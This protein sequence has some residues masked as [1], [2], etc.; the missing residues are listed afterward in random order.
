MRIPIRISLAAAA[1]LFALVTTVAA[2]ADPTPAARYICPPCSQ[3]CDTMSFDHPGTCPACGMTLVLAADAGTPPDTRRKVAILVFPGVEIIDSMGPYEV[4]GAA[5][6]NVYSVGA[7]RDP[8][9]SAMG[10][11][12]TP[13]YTFDDAPVPDVLVV[14]GGGVGNALHSDRT[15]DWI[16]AITGKDGQTMSVCNGAFILA[17]AGL[18]DGLSATTTA[19]NI[20]KLAEQYPKIHVVSDQRY[21]DNGHIVTTAGLSAGIDGALHVVARLDGDGFAQEVALA[22]EYPWTPKGG[23]ARAAMADQLIPQVDFDALG[24][25]KLVSTHGTV[26]HWEIVVRGTS[27][28]SAAELMDKVSHTLSEKGKWRPAT[29]TRSASANDPIENRWRFAGQKGEPWRGTV[30][31]T[32]VRGE[33]RAYVATLRVAQGG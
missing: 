33:E 4:F 32:P 19:H 21:V 25:W 20:P 29:G 30:T 18:L 9:T 17:S 3:P 27:T 13:K 2:Y 1:V 12:F 6:Y 14:P 8:V 15:L 5:G 7:T 28:L 26:D 23:F 16:R 22:E 24:K 10:Q 31:I 11:L